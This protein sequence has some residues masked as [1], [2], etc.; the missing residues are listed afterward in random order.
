MG[1]VQRSRPVEHGH[2]F[3]RSCL[4]PFHPP[5]LSHVFSLPSATTALLR[6]VPA[7][8]HRIRDAR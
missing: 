4:S 1:A 6:C 8:I 2:H 3:V 5:V 7:V